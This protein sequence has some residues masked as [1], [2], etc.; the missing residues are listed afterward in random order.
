MRGNGTRSAIRYRVIAASTTSTAAHA[1]H[2]IHVMKILHV[3]HTVHIVH[4]TYIAHLYT[5]QILVT[6][7]HAKTHTYRRK[8]LWT[9]INT[10]IHAHRTSNRIKH[11]HI[12]AYTYTYPLQ[13]TG[14]WNCIDCVSGQLQIQGCDLTSSSLTCVSVHRK[15]TK[16]RYQVPY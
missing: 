11:S 7:L 14:F 16:P 3:I 2:V 9:H 10:S 8:C 4:I 15:D 5:L 6:Y 13:G 12:L 1:I